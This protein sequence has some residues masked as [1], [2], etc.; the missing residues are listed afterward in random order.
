MAAGDEA[1]AA[2]LSVVPATADVRQGYAAINT[3]GDELARHQTSGTHPFTRITGQAQTAQIA[4]S[5]ITKAKMAADSVGYWQIETGA[6]TPSK[7]EDGAVGSAKLADGAVRT[8]KIANRSVT[9]GKLAQRWA[10][11]AATV[12]VGG[13]LTVTHGLG[14]L[15][16]QPAVVVTPDNPLVQVAAEA[17]SSTSFAIY[18]RS[19]AVQGSVRVSWL[20]A[21]VI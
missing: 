10:A 9:P 3:R 21:E 16:A 7:I 20:V 6:V 12:P 5:A 8:A 18:A 14:A 4:D 1:A 19:T 13:S 17:A 2:G 15:P 11:G